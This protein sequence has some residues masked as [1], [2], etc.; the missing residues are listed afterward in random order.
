MA[1]D[2][3]T[4]DGLMHRRERQ[5]QRF[6]IK[7]SNFQFDDGF[8]VRRQYIHSA[9]SSVGIHCAWHWIFW[10]NILHDTCVIWHNNIFRRYIL[11]MLQWNTLKKENETLHK[12]RIFF[13]LVRKK[14]ESFPPLGCDDYFRYLSLFIYLFPPASFFQLFLFFVRLFSVS[15]LYRCVRCRFHDSIFISFLL[16]KTWISVNWI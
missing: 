14:R 1:V 7:L 10:F 8:I 16:G 13:P 3:D 11:Q 5:T 2:W 12:N 4:L 15:L 9:R 6:S